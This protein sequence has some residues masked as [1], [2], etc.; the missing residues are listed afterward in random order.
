MLALIFAAGL[1]YAHAGVIQSF[2]S[3]VS[4]TGILVA[5]GAGST[6]SEF[7]DHIDF[8]QISYASPTSLNVSV[9]WA[10]TNTGSFTA[11]NG[12]HFKVFYFNGSAW[13]TVLSDLRSPAQFT[14]DQHI[15]TNFTFNIPGGLAAPLGAHYLRASIKDL[16]SSGDSMTGNFA[17]DGGF[18]S[19]FDNADVG[20]T[21][22]AGVNTAPSITNNASAATAS[23]SFP[24]NS[25]ATII[26]I[27]AT[28]ADAGQTITFSK[29][30][31]DAALFNLS[32]DGVLTFGSGRDFESFSDANLNGVYEVTVT[33]TDNGSP[34]NLSDSQALSITV[35]NVNEIPSFVKG[36]DQLLPY[37]TSSA[38]TAAGWA[39]AINDGDSTVTQALTFNISSNSNAGLFTTGP[40]IDSSTGTLTYT[41]NGTAGTATIGVTLTD[42]ATSM[43]TPL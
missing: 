13:S 3:P 28:D 9:Q 30:G 40:S 39:T 8:I 29:S 25:T 19:H 5:D 23:L 41:P 12:I 22:I 14:I 42:D 35:T 24:E 33:A 16:A 34:S 7:D 11:T 10:P 37:N 1:P 31:A 32:A 15:T 38:Q 4:G 43:A 2:G 26:D 17:D 18:G 27:D 20:F 36:A 21:V 6:A